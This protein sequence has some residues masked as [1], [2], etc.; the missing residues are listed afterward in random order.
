ME[1][2]NLFLKKCGKCGKKCN[3]IGTFYEGFLRKWCDKCVKEYVLVI[4]GKKCEK[5][6]KYEERAKRPI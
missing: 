5:C 1:K 3:H 4:S 6:I 2:I